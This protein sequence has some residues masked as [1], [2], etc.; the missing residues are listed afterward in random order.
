MN[1]R[2]LKDNVIFRSFLIQKIS[3]TIRFFD[4]TEFY[5]LHGDDADFAAKAVFK[6][7]ANIK[8]MA[9]ADDEELR[10][11]VLSK[12]NFENLVRELLIVK[13]YRVEVY[14]SKGG[15]RTND[16]SIEYKGSPGNLLQFEELLFSNNEMVNGSAL[17]ALLLKNEN[18]QKVRKSVEC[19]IFF[20]YFF[21]RILDWPML[22]PTREYFL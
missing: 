2:K 13:N 9:G 18:Q 5:S 22:K 19:R 21:F 4:R 12:G 1:S 11:V 15:A 16:W 6:S 8:I 7:T 3:T 10:Y 14:T 20:N 17:I